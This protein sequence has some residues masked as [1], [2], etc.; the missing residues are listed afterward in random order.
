MTPAE[1]HRPVVVIT[2][3][4]RGIGRAAALAF[5]RAGYRVAGIHRSSD[6][7]I[8]SELDAD[9]VAAGG[10][11]LIDFGSIAATSDIEHLAASVLAR[12]GTIDVWINNASSFAMSSFLDAEDSEWEETLQVNV[13]GY[14]RGCRAAARAMV[15][16]GSG[17]IINIGSA[18]DPH[19]PALSSTYTTTKAA[20]AGL[21]RA[22]AVELGPL[23][24]RVNTVSPGPTETTLNQGN[25][26]D[27]VRHAYQRKIPLARIAAPEDIADALVTV[28]SP[29]F[30]F[31]NGQTVLVDGGMTLNGTVG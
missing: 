15:A 6:V 20:I 21:T 3:I 2:G 29:G 4:S 5:A 28:A 27:T 7:R 14:V 17:A 8:S 1:H 19:P 22:L 12:W 30:R 26:N 18:A 13:M 9:I 16:A 23:G 11:A 31:V 10:E 24:V 25:W